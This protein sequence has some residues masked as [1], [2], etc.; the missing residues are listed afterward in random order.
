MRKQYEDIE[1]DSTLKKLDSDFLWKVRQKQELK[2]RILTDIELIESQG[3]HNQSMFHEEK[4][5][6]KNWTF[7][8]LKYI[9]VIALVSMITFSS[10]LASPAFANFVTQIPVIGSVFNYFVY[11]KAYYGAYKDLSTEIGIVEESKD[12]A[13]IIDQAVYDGNMVTLSF[14]IKTNEQ[15][16]T[17]P[18]FENLPIVQ[19][20][21]SNT[22]YDVKY[23]KDVGYVGVMTLSMFEDNR[24]TVNIAWKPK[25]ISSDNRTLQGDW[26]FKFSLNEI[27]NTSIPINQE[28][29]KNGVTV[30]LIEARK[31]DV[32]LSITYSQVIDASLLESW[33]AVEAEL[34]AIDNI[35]NEYK[36]PYNGGEGMEDS[37]SGEDIIWNATIHGLDEKATSITFYPFAHISN[38]PSDSGEAN[39]NRIDFDPITVNLK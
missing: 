5:R 8:V 21:F 12:V 29:S 2:N 28:V 18:K 27:P 16:G 7:P 32:N 25:A 38:L 26:A 33:E 24:K 13:L 6:K 20:D 23:V 36:V 10:A 4:V 37:I 9:A 35:G 3:K 22:S 34:Y 1:F 17:L 11:D 15:F 19:G 39:S 31:T 30:R 14:I